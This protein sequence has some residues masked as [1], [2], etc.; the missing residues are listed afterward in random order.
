MASKTAVASPDPEP[1]AYVIRTPTIGQIDVPIVGIEPLLVHAWS[2]K[3]R[4]MMLKGQQKE[5]AGNKARTPREKRDPVADFNGA[6]YTCTDGKK[7]WDGFPS[8]GFK[9]SLVGACRQVDGLAMTDARRILFVRNDGVTFYNSPLS[10][11]TTIGLVRIFGE[12]EMREDT[13]RID[14]G[15]TTNLAYRPQYWPWSA[16]LRIE[17]NASWLSLESVYNLVAT[18][19]AFEGVG[20]WR[21]G[22]KLSNSGQLGRW[23]LDESKLK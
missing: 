22:S 21:P 18:A 10:C 15:K 3:A 17:F 13:V 23:K 4:A 6:R 8:V 12:P 7:Q 14:N 5:E 20:E 9:A 2:A 16:V 19:G 1:K 11:K